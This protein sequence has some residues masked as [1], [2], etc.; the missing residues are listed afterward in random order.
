L[1]LRS[2]DMEYDETSTPQ[3]VP[4]LALWFSVCTEAVLEAKRG[5]KAALAWIWD[6]EQFETLCGL[7]DLNVEIVRKQVVPASFVEWIEQVGKQPVISIEPE[8]TPKRK[9]H[10]TC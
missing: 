4:E 1:R 5:S 6:S 10:K 3:T 8:P 9:R 7:L 2:A